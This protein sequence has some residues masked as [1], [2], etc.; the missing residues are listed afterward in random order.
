[1]LEITSQVSHY[2]GEMVTQFDS[3]S[4]EGV[5]LTLTRQ[6]PLKAAIDNLW[7]NSGWAQTA[8]CSRGYQWPGCSELLT[9]LPLDPLAPFW[10][11]FHFS[12]SYPELSYLASRSA[13]SGWL[14]KCQACIQN[15][16]EGSRS[17]SLT[18]IGGI[19]TT[20]RPHPVYYSD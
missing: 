16:I 18:D 12:T 19:T 1:M 5:F 13:T 14:V 15:D 9:H 6:T 8:S 2:P 17:R 10:G 7:Y 20:I 4:A 11:D 3:N